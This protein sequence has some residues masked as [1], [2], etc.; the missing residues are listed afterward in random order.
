M[1]QK[2]GKAKITSLIAQIIASIWI[3]VW[4]AVKFVKGDSEVM[5]VILSGLAIAACFS[6]VYFNIM[7]D[8]IKDI[9]FGGRSNDNAEAEEK[10]NV[11]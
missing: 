8:K 6:P 3:S 11:E 7:L 1:G 9:R 5:D 2:S 4:C 10:E